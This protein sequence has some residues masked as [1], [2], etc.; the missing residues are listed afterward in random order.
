METLA[1]KVP[2]KS[3][4]VGG[5]EGYNINSVNIRY[6]GSLAPGA[7]SF[8]MIRERG[9]E[10]RALTKYDEWLAEYMEE[11]VAKYP[12]KVV[13]VHRRE[14]VFVGDIESDIYRK[15]REAGLE[16]MPPVFRIPRKEDL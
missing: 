14:I 9:M 16:P 1:G 11:L 2:R 13:A 4:F 15:V 5:V 10:S 3:R 7:E 8:I 6:P 12:A